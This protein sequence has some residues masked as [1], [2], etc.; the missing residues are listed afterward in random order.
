MCFRRRPDA[1]STTPGLAG[2]HSLREGLDRLLAGTGLTSRRCRTTA[3]RADHAGAERHGAERNAG[4]EALPA[5][6][7]GAERPRDGRAEQWQAGP[8][9]AELLCRADRLDGDQDRHAGDEHA[10]QCAGDHAE[11]DRGSAGDD[12][13]GRFAECQRRH[14]PR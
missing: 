9:A 7:I 12:L 10:G 11:G 2:S 14:R 4:A 1:G 5:I 13:A 3:A 8:H 6:D